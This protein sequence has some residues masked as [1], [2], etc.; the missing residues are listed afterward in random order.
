[1]K[2][3]A[4]LLILIATMVVF[5]CYYGSKFEELE[6]NMVVLQTAFSSSVCEPPENG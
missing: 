4:V 1:M 2:D 3:F 5:H 6:L